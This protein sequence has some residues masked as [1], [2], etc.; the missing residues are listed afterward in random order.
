MSGRIW[1]AKELAYVRR[2]Y[3][4]VPAAEIGRRLGR[5]RPAVFRAADLLGIA[6][7]QRTAVERARLEARIRRWH[8]RGWCDAEIAAK[9]KTDRKWICD[10]RRGMGLPPNGHN[11]RHRR[12]VAA[13]TRAQLATAGVRSL[14]E[15]KREVRRGQARDLG[16]PEDLRWRA[17]QIL[18]ALW[19]RGPQTREQLAAVIGMPWKGSRKSLGSNDPEGSY[20]AN[21]QARG[22]VV[23]LGRVVKKRGS[24]KS[25]NLYSLPLWIRKEGIYG[26]KQ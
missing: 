18:E 23:R 9:C 1:T 17:V 13:K 7:R 22:L 2:W 12:R 4:K 26:E 25:V 11:Q 14:A 20:L 15:L 3:R 8:A 24:G 16:W 21:L 5:S 10:L 19:V 6:G